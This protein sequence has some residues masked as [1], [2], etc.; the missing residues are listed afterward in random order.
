MNRLPTLVYL[1]NTFWPSSISC[2]SH[3]FNSKFP[4]ALSINN[5][6]LFVHCLSVARDQTIYILQSCL[7][8][9]FLSILDA[10]RNDKKI[11]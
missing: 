8:S 4:P 7:A 6:L 3:V 5:A 1:I 2:G 10:L 9:R 11:D